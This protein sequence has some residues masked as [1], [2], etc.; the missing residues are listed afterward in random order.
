MPLVAGAR[1]TS[2]KPYA[3]RGSARILDSTADDLP[4]VAAG[5]GRRHRHD[6]W[7]IRESAAAAAAGLFKEHVIAVPGDI[8]NSQNA[9]EI[10]IVAGS[11]VHRAGL[12]DAL[13][14][15]D[16]GRISFTDSMETAFRRIGASDDVSIDPIDVVLADL[17]ILGERCHEF[18]ARLRNSPRHHD[19]PVLALTAAMTPGRLDDLVRIGFA[20]YVRKPLDATAIRARLTAANAFRR[21]LRDSRAREAELQRRE[22]ELVEV[23]RLLEDSNERLRYMSTLDVLTGIPNR[24]RVMEFLDQEWRRAVREGSWLSVVMIDVDHFK[25]FNDALGHLAGDDCL[26]MVA[27]CLKRCL[28]RAADMAGRYGGE[29][30]IVV[31]P[32]TPTDGAQLVGDTIRDSIERLAIEHPRSTTAS[33]ITASLGVASCVPDKSFTAAK[34]ILLADRALY[35]AKSEGRNRIVM[36]DG[37]THAASPQSPGTD[38]TS[39]TPA[40]A[41]VVGQ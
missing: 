10:L 12:R 11:D 27:N 15:L 9:G 36:A 4:K 25:N 26:W 3:T 5:L 19:T 22:T 2:L 7:S 34:L 31:L 8:I 21:A 23:T 28:N 30:F 35:R 16:L 41:D 29:E 20:D 38:V 40:R 32:E 33:V 18:F 1:W 13:V 37:M 14:R 39:A 6:S 17:D 24:R